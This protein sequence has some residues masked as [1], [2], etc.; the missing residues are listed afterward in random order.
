MTDRLAHRGPD[1]AATQCHGP[2]A[3]GHTLLS[4][5]DLDGGAQPMPSPD[6]RYVIVYNGEVYNYQALRTELESAGE[7]FRTQ[8]DTEVVAAAFSRWGAECLSR[9]RGMFAFVILDTKTGALFAARDRIGI[10][11]LFWHES[12]QVCIF[13]SEMKA[14]FASGRDEP[15]F[16]PLAVHDLMTF[17][18]TLG[19]YTPFAGIREVPPG[20]CVRVTRERSALSRYWAMPLPGTAAPSI[21]DESAKSAFYDRFNGT[22]ASHLIGDV[23]IACYLSGGIDSNAVAHSLKALEFPVYKTYSM[24]FDVAACDESEEIARSAKVH[25]FENRAVQLGPETLL[26]YARVVEHLEQPQW[27]TIDAALYRLA[28]AVR[29]DGI[30]V[31][32][33]GQGSDELLAGYHVFRHDV[34]RRRLRRFPWS[35]VR[36]PLM[37]SALQ[38]AGN[39]PDMIELL[40]AIERRPRRDVESSYGLWPSRLTEWNLLAPLAADALAEPVRRAATNAHERQRSWFAREIKPNVTGGDPLERMLYVE[41]RTRLPSFVLW[42][43]DRMNMAHGVEARPPFVDHEFVEYCAALPTAVKLRGA[44][45]KWILRESLRGRLHRRQVEQPKRP[46]F[47]PVNE[48]LRDAAIRDRVRATLT[49]AAITTAGVF[50]P[51]AVLAAMATSLDEPVPAPPT[52]KSVR[53]DWLVMLALG[54]QHLHSMASAPAVGGDRPGWNR[55]PS[56]S[57]RGDGAWAKTPS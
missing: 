35:L 56:R 46:F 51:D 4:I 7:R 24:T 16:D 25:G 2:V 8:T 50:D 23:P 43:E 39:A 40:M 12:D 30:K 3:L 37:R 15:R 55:Q 34:V 27:W 36:T 29:A 41:C 31:S 33:S 32:L 6:G 22:V 26:D 20:C 11:P 57:P 28:A 10:K 42:K 49:P 45:D 54:Y 52:L 5:V 21:D 38:Q 47:S 13:A 1:G 19:E 44:Q 53:A 48:W 9:L 17:G 14:I 18:H